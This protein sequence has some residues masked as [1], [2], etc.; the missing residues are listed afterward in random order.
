MSKVGLL[1][2]WLAAITVVAS[3]Q[4]GSKP[5]A[6]SFQAGWHAAEVDANQVRAWVIN[7]GVLGR[8]PVTGNAGCEYPAGSGRTVLF[9]SGLWIAGVVNGEVRTACANYNTEFQPGRILPTG[10]ADDRN[11]PCYRVYK[12]KP[13]DSADPTSPRYNVDYAE[14]PNAHGAPTNPD[15]SP[16]VLGDVTL[17]YVMNDADNNRHNIAYHTKP[18]GVEVQ[19]LVWAFS[20]PGG[21]LGKTIFVEYTIINK[22][23]QL[24]DDAY[25]G[26]WADPD[27]GGASDDGSACDTTLD[28]TYTYNRRLTDPVYGPAVPAWG[29]MLLQGPAVPAPGQV[30]YQFRRGFVPGARNLRASAN[31]VYYCAHPLFYAPPYAPQGAFHIHCNMRGLDKDGT[32]L[33]DPS[34]GLTTT[35]MNSGDPIA[36]TGWLD[37]L[38]TPPCDVTFM[39]ATGP[40]SMA[41]LD[42]QQ[43]VYALAIGD[44][45]DALTS[46]MALKSEACYA[47]AALLSGFQVEP[48]LYSLLHKVGAAA[49][50]GLR[51]KMVSQVGV[52]VVNADFTDYRGA[53]VE[54]LPLYDDGAHDD[55]LANDGVYANV[56]HT[57]LRDEAVH[58]DLHVKDEQGREHVFA[59]LVGGLLLTEGWRVLTPIVVADHLNCDGIVNPGEVVKIRL[60]IVNRFPQE[61][62]ALTATVQ[63]L[64]PLAEL[65]TPVLRFEQIAPFDTAGTGED[66]FLIKF[67][68]GVTHPDTVD[69]AVRLLDSDYHL[70]SDVFSLP[71]EP[72]RYLPNEQLIFQE[73][74]RSDAFF[75]IRVVDPGQLTGH[76]YLITLSDSI[77]PRGERGFNLWDQTLGVV[78]LSRHPLPDSLAFNVPVTDGF[79]VVE[80]YLPE[81]GLRGVA[82]RDVPGGMPAGLVGV[83]RGGQFF[84]GGVRLGMAPKESFYEVEL[85]FV[86]SIDTSGV[87][88]TPLGQLAFRYLPVAGA[89]ADG[90]YR[91]PFR[92]WKI[93]AG[94]RAGLLNVCFQELPGRPT[95]DGIWAPDASANGG[96][97]TL[98]LMA[99][100]YDSS[101]TVYL[102]RVL[103]GDEVLYEATF[104]LA[105]PA[106]SVDPG[107]AIL[108]DWEHPPGRDAQFPFVPTGVKDGR[109]VKVARSFQLYQNY[110]NPFN[111][112]TTI[113]FALDRGA[114]VVL[115]VWNAAGRQV[116]ELC[117]GWRAAGEHVVKW[118][119]RD[120]QGNQAGSG[121]YL[122]RLTAGQ[123]VATI[124]M[125]LLK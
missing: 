71:V 55:S 50:I 74:R 16:V 20:R 12:I 99:T 6:T 108:F 41:P 79:K 59:H 110:P 40:F 62:L 17:W 25:V 7:N 95:W 65:W 87:V 69:F 46:I 103:P 73:P 67:N 32:P 75:R 119:G 104:R 90:A 11:L 66:C 14:W 38:F 53:L 43:V 2:A 89:A 102:N 39:Q 9:A 35:F 47:R 52:C 80:A 82:Y 115:R 49:E 81:G 91:C 18:L 56:W 13:G 96:L 37:D 24:I 98:Y 118:D 26:F 85:E 1:L 88:G 120:S 57:P 111:A 72:F 93:V 28:L 48:R 54:R 5:C 114:R 30:A 36:R 61:M 19:V 51:L 124:K 101:G 106:A 68:P 60:P 97:E 4:A 10:Q 109:H 42:T 63:T 100:D 112:G 83:N 33:V 45:G 44:G 121:L 76:A 125:L 29:A 21:L 94:E 113:R 116:A 23:G 78:L 31:A 92:A 86:N 122:A 8:D 77:N 123:D 70:R 117:N 15:G 58:L 105:S 64:S 107:D 27:L 22:G 84:G 3:V 34:S